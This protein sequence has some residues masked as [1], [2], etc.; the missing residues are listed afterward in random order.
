MSNRPVAHIDFETRSACDL[1]AAGAYRYA[2]DPSTEIVCMAWSVDDGPIAIWYPGQPW[3]DFPEDAMFTAHNAGFERA[4]WNALAPTE[5]KLTPEDMDCTM[6]RALAVSLPASL[7]M[8][9]QVLKLPVQKDR[10]GHKLMLK[11]CKPRRIEDDGRIVWWGEAADHEAL[12]AYCVRDVETEQGCASRVPPLPLG[13]RRVWRLDQRINDRGFPLDVP[14]VQAA[15]R[16]VGDARQRADRRIWRLTEGS[17]STC[18]QVAKI[19]AW[20]SSR[21]IPCRSIGKGEMQDLLI[22]ADAFDDP[23]VEEALALRKAAGKSSTAKFKALLDCVCS[24][25]RVRGTLAYHG[26]HT[27]RWAGR[28]VQPQNFP[29][30]D[31]HEAV[32]HA[33]ELLKRPDAVDA[34]EAVFGN[35]LEILSQCLRAMIRAPKGKKLIGGDFANI[36][37]RVNAWIAGEEWKLRAFALYDRGIG[38]DLYRLSYGRAFDLE[39]E[40]VDSAG[41]QVGK[42]MELALGYQGGV[43]A[44][45]KMAAGYGV[46]VSDSRA[47]DLKRAWRDANPAIA[48]SWLELQR[49]GL[50]AV[51]A[52]GMVREALYDRVGY[53]SDGRYLY[54]RLPSGR[55]LHYPSP[56]ARWKTHVITIDGE[57]ETFA[58]RGVTYWGVNSLTKQ[59]GPLD[60]YGGS[61]CNHVVQGMARDLMVEA[62]HRLEAAGYRIFLTV[63]DEILCEVDEDFGSVSEF[64]EIMSVLPP[65]AEGLPVATKAWEDERYVK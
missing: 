15:L 23:V 31:D 38:P 24:D 2:Q 17:A 54:C 65:W 11:M 48:K 25:G 36:E 63:H 46:R 26:A 43:G 10:Y 60:L 61:Q 30:V 29:R 40:A 19:A 4:I 39:P 57:E 44:F 8:L 22:A 21:G 1:K 52:R 3:P 35:P 53:V 5:F 32:A 56:E 9:G 12:R 16:A 55:S 6:A 51:D 27:G 34:L 7:D 62:M 41:R 14:A 47:D 58:S 59:W 18:S 49:A 64:E 28:L 13:E 37:G 42:V 33:L 45:Q 20:I 50:D